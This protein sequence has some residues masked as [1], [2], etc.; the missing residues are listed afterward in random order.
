MDFEG[1]GILALWNG[2]DA[3]R[4]EEYNMWHSRE[5]V[6]ERLSVPGMRSARRYV[7][8][9]GELPEYL[10]LYEVDN[11]SVLESQPYLKLLENPTEWSSS[12]RPSFRGF[13]RKC[14]NRIVSFGGGMGSTLVT[15][16]LGRDFEGSAKQCEALI[17][18]VVKDAGP[19]VAT[20]LIVES[21]DIPP[22]PFTIGGDDVL[23][24]LTGAVL[25]ESYDA[26]SA[27]VELNRLL[28]FFADCGIVHEDVR[29][30]FYG[31][32]YALNVKSLEHIVP[33]SKSNFKVTAGWSA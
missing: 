12:M 25:L 19:F 31:L 5:H 21:P 3:S 24:P 18:H 26:Q 14:C 10:T 20:H 13:L 2:A 8:T 7:R 16:P 11:L 6:P 9:S 29:A 17:E 15:L 23:P 27:E 1:E 30:S 4:S 32:V 28:P 33:M 22:V